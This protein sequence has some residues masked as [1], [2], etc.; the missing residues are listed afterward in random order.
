MLGRMPF[1]HYYGM[2][3]KYFLQQIPPSRRKGYLVKILTS[4]AAI[5][6]ETAPLLTVTLSLPMRLRSTVP[7]GRLLRFGTLT[8]CGPQPLF[9]HTTASS[10]FFERWKA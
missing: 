7:F 3:P 10:P 2:W 4:L 1:H 6:H 8:L 9:M 5:S